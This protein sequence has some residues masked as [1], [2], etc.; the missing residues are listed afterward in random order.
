MLSPMIQE[1][2]VTQD[3]YGSQSG[4]CGVLLAEVKLLLIGPD[5]LPYAS[6]VSIVFACRRGL[7]GAVVSTNS[8]RLFRRALIYQTWLN[9]GVRCMTDRRRCGDV[10]NAILNTFDTRRIQGVNN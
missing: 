2:G 9:L 7:S 5:R 6:K 10:P 1:L 8:I 4:P 3:E